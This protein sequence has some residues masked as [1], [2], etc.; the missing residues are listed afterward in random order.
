MFKTFVCLA[1]SLSVNGH[2]TS[3]NVG[4]SNDES[5]KSLSDISREF[6]QMELNDEFG[7][8]KKAMNMKV[9]PLS[10][11]EKWEKGLQH[12]VTEAMK[13]QTLLEND[14][15]K[16]LS[17]IKGNFKSPTSSAYA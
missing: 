13:N 14:V 11:L 12:R 16:Q 9:E 10:D 1:L 2:P 17:G 5:T 8:L 3:N 7:Y 15:E 6:A 4:V